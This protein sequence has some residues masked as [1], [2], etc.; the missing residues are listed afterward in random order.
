MKS[1]PIFS[2][3]AIEVAIFNKKYHVVY[4]KKIL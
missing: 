1:Y 4:V 3:N 2:A